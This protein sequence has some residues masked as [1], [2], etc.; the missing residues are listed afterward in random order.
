MPEYIHSKGMKCF[1]VAL[2]IIM[3]IVISTCTHFHMYK[4]R[5]M[6]TCTHFHMYKIRT[7]TWM[8]LACICE[9]TTYRRHEKFSCSSLRSGSVVMWPIAEVDYNGA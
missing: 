4:M 8:I 5:I 9:N 1:L 6:Y 2:R 7:C 3:F